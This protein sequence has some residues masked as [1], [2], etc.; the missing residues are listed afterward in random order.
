MK[1]RMPSL[2]RHLE[3]VL[4]INLDVAQQ[5]DCFS[6]GLKPTCL[7]DLVP[8]FFFFFL[9]LFIYSRE[10]QRERGAE[11]QAEGEAGSMQGARCGTRSRVSRITPWAEGGAKPKRLSKVACCPVASSLPSPQPSTPASAGAP[12]RPVP[13]PAAHPLAAWHPS[14]AN[15]RPAE[16]SPT[17]PPH[18]CL[19]PVSHEAHC[20]IPAVCFLGSL[21]VLGWELL[22]TEALLGFP[23]P[24]RPRSLTHAAP[25]RTT[26][27]ATPPLSTTTHSSTISYHD[28]KRC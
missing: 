11:T 28:F 6:P 18:P 15:H 14:G 17:F 12:A 16:P 19:R 10:T 27:T 26:R 1:L 25:G 24:Y 20:A 2:R 13:T 7:Q 22:G 3:S 9:Y 21:L 23:V 4:H 8:A 5:S